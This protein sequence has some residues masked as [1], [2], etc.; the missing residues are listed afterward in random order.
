MVSCFDNITVESRLDLVT[1]HCL[2]NESLLLREEQRQNLREEWQKSSPSG[3]PCRDFGDVG[4]GGFKV[5]VDD[6]CCMLA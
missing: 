3:I 2:G 4:L 1:I 6:V 5:R